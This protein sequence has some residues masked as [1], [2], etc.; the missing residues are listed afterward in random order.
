VSLARCVMLAFVCVNLLVSW[1]SAWS[2]PE[3]GVFPEIA[4]RIVYE[5]PDGIYLQ[6]TGS[7]SAERIVPGGAYPRWSPDGKVV[8]YV[9]AHAIGII[10]LVD[11][12]QVILAQAAFPH[13]VAFHP[14]GEMI[15]FTDGD[16]IKAVNWKTCAIV[17]IVKGKKYR[18]L[19]VSE[20]VLAVT[21]HGLGFH[22]ET[23]NLDTRE[24]KWIARGCSASLSP[25]GDRVTVNGGGHTRLD[26][27]DISNG[28]R[29]AQVDAPPG[30]TFDNQFWSNA[31]DWVV[32]VVEKGGQDVYIHQI[33]TNRSWRVTSSGDCNR[34]DLYLD[35]SRK[36]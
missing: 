22:V 12:R 14:G 17:S 23:M 10:S 9:Q 2:A 36:R 24:S 5:R 25:S 33:S 16:E 18:E 34:P 31:Q 27:Y 28:K 19:D 6:Q 15:W 4:G 20:H 29:L 35:V 13:A 30:N 7:S 8:A 1:D 3:N 26:I 11:R 21:V 32:S